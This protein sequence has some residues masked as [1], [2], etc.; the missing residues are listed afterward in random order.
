MAA[1]ALGS[2]LLLAACGGEGSDDTDATS[3]GDSATTTSAAAD[4]GDDGDDS[5]SSAAPVTDVCGLLTD[6]EVEAAVG[7][8]VAGKKPGG[9]QGFATGSCGWEVSGPTSTKGIYAILVSVKSPKGKAQFD[10]LESQMPAIPGLGDDAYQQGD[11]IWAVR[12]DSL[13]V[14]GYGF[15][16]ADVEDERQAAINVAEAVLSKL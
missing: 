9:G 5:G 3:V 14:V 1:L 8:P 6:A 7:L 4:D 15:L 12:G 2:A 16:S 11:S 13:V 10:I